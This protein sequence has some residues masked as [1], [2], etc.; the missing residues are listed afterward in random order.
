MGSGASAARIQSSTES[1]GEVL[2]REVIPNFKNAKAMWELFK[3]GSLSQSKEPIF[4]SRISGLFT[5]LEIQ[6]KY[7]EKITCL[8][9]KI[10]IDQILEILSK[11]SSQNLKK[12]AIIS[13]PVGQGKS[14]ISAKILQNLQ[15][16]KTSKLFYRFIDCTSRTTEA[17]ALVQDICMEIY[18]SSTADAEITM[19][20]FSKSAGSALIKNFEIIGEE[21]CILILDG[22][23]SINNV[24]DLLQWLRPLI[25]KVPD[26]LR[27]LLTCNIEGFSS[28]ADAFRKII[29]TQKKNCDHIQW[30]QLEAFSEQEESDILQYW[31]TNEKVTLTDQIKV[32]IQSAMALASE[33][34]SNSPL[35]LR[36][37][38]EQA[39]SGEMKDLPS[40]STEA[41]ENLFMAAENQFGT[42]AI[43]LVL[44]LITLSRDGL[45]QTEISDI[46]SSPSVQCICKLTKEQAKT[47][48]TAS[49][50]YLYSLL[51][52]TPTSDKSRAQAAT[53]I[54]LSQGKFTD[55][56]PKLIRWRHANAEAV[57]KFRYFNISHRDKISAKDQT[58]VKIAS[59]IAE[60]FWAMPTSWDVQ[61]DQSDPLLQT[62]RPIGQMRNVRRVRELAHACLLSMDFVM[63]SNILSDIG[64]LRGICEVGGSGVEGCIR[65]V[66]EALNYIRWESGSLRSN[67]T[68]EIL[69]DVWIYLSMNAR[70]LQE[71]ENDFL[72]ER[73]PSMWLQALKEFENSLDGIHDFESKRNR[74]SEIAKKYSETE[75]CEKYAFWRFES[76]SKRW[77]NQRENF[78]KQ[79]T[80]P[81]RTLKFEMKPGKKVIFSV[82]KLIVSRCGTYILC[83][84][85]GTTLTMWETKSS[86]VL[87]SLEIQNIVLS[88]AFSNDELLVAVFDGNLISIRESDLGTL[89]SAIIVKE[90][91]KN[92]LSNMSFIDGTEKKSQK[93]IGSHDFGCLISWDLSRISLESNSPCHIAP[94]FV[95]NENISTAVSR[96][97]SKHSFS[98]SQDNRKVIWWWY[99]GTVEN[100]EL[101]VSSLYLTG[102]KFSAKELWRNPVTKGKGNF[103]IDVK[104]TLDGQKI[105]TCSKST[106][107]C[108]NE[109]DGKIIWKKETIENDS[110]INFFLAWD[111]KYIVTMRES[112]NVIALN[113]QLENEDKNLTLIISNNKVDKIAVSTQGSGLLI[114]VKCDS[115]TTQGEIWDLN[116]LFKKAYIENMKNTNTKN[117]IAFGQNNLKFKKDPNYEKA[118]V[119]AVKDDTN[120][121]LI[122]EENGFE[123]CNFK[124]NRIIPN[125]N[126]KVIWASILGEENYLVAFATE[127]GRLC[128]FE[129]QKSFEKP[130]IDFM[131]TPNGENL[132]S[133][134]NRLYQTCVQKYL[135]AISCAETNSIFVLDLKRK[136][137]ILWSISDPSQFMGKLQTITATKI[138]AH[139]A[140]MWLLI[141]FPSG[142]LEIRDFINGKILILLASDIFKNTI[143]SNIVSCAFSS[144]GNDVILSDE[145]GYGY[146]LGL[147]PPGKGMQFSIAPS[148]NDSNQ[149]QKTTVLEWCYYPI[150]DEVNGR[151]ALGI[152]SDGFM[153]AWDLT[154]TT[155]KVC[156]QVKVFEDEERDRRCYLFVSKKQQ[157]IK[158]PKKDNLQVEGEYIVVGDN[159]GQFKELIL[160]RGLTLR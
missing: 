106:I 44:S 55:H 125:P 152:C 22:L 160:Q 60:Y 71:S 87:W 4:S 52:E 149:S 20:F 83:V 130:I 57:A 150:L 9:R 80:I 73:G 116:E 156:A 132:G 120:V 36:L 81:I 95:G 35:L 11:I 115:N 42:S 114:V 137:K 29:Q 112:G 96:N 10:L 157:A 151:C 109:T 110:F 99:D 65:E 104:F 89:L 18:L 26:N 138:S 121:C 82:T 28:Y 141:A 37:L 155:P 51:A 33:M 128:A 139:S 43:R 23:D 98:L 7:L 56:Y 135:V 119:I 38:F 91:L 21:N 154:E 85:D 111:M 72:S 102:K 24:A 97:N 19:P 145:N 78:S 134:R 68:L 92:V 17:L 117:F 34:S 46:I 39:R 79:T 148:I 2:L 146:L 45:S 136:G 101:C 77:I 8:G 32:Q 140:N 131:P 129:I 13:A 133:C 62:V 103:F 40:T 69:S 126:D 61:G 5:E 74:W 118:T 63:L 76:T 90:E 124:Y 113:T 122:H 14:T 107:S 108:L 94:N 64:Y 84:T 48:V 15:Q 31:I 100:F 1:S 93:I 70:L 47:L 25:L 105:I 153:R 54:I 86:E 6:A 41:I 127:N 53:H 88:A 142:K 159:T 58:V 147:N 143:R 67:E 27:I 66:E 16:Q 49:L 30:F 123:V 144:M 75:V 50:S 12:V 59:L 3:K 158:I